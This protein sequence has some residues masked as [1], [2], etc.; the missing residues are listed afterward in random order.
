[1]KRLLLLIA[2]LCA[3]SVERSFAQDAHVITLNQAN[4]VAQISITLPQNSTGVV[5]IGV[6]M[7]SIQVTDTSNN[8][9]FSAADPRVHWVEL[10]IA[11]NTGTHLLTV[12][13]LPGVQSASLQV[14]SQADLTATTGAGSFVN[15]S[16]PSF[17]QLQPL[18]LTTQNPQGSVSMA[19]PQDTTG[20]VTA[21]FVGATATSQVTDAN[22]MVVASTNRDVD[23]FNLVLDS[24]GYKFNLAAN[25]LNNPITA[26]VSVMPASQFSL[27]TAAA[28]P[29]PSPTPMVVV[30]PCIATITASSANLRSGPGRGYTVLNFAYLGDTLTVGGVNADHSWLVVAGSQGS[31]WLSGTLAQLSGDCS[32]LQVFNV[33]FLNEQP[34]Q[35]N[36]EPA[37]TQSF[38]NPTSGVSNPPPSSNPPQHGSHDGGDDSGSDD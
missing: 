20:V 25:Q 32:N 31:A 24:G 22:G 18:P 13:P 4:P 10:S 28:A 27:L 37:P 7:A 6:N 2:V 12:Q 1:M 8:V 5:S 11:P 34:A 17:P 38:S 35:I 33:A 36:I 30:Q 3:L 16:D 14:T 19:I 15:V 21:T 9:I 26:N 29:A 23:G